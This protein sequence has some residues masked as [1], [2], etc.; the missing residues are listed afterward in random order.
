MSLYDQLNEEQL[1]T[2]REC[3]FGPRSLFAHRDTVEEAQKYLE[4]VAQATDS[5]MHI[6]TAAMVLLQ[7]FLLQMVIEG[8]LVIPEGYYDE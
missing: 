7:T 4:S 3:G 2:M 8:H 6:Y 1:A 5:P